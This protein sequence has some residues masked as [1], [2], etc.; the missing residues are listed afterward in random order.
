MKNIHITE[1][2]S[3]T[4]APVK[5]DRFASGVGFK[6]LTKHYDYLINNFFNVDE[7]IDRFIGQIDVRPGMKLL[8]V[9]C[10]TGN[11]LISL[12]S[13]IPGV[14]LFGIDID[15]EMIS[16]S[17]NKMDLA[18]LN[19]SVKLIQSSADVLPFEPESLDR[20]VSSLALHHLPA[21][22]R[23]KHLKRSFEILKPG[24][25]LH[26]MDWGKPVSLL[27]HVGATF[28]ILTDGYS[29]FS[30][31]LRGKIPERIAEAG[32]VEIQEYNTR[33]ETFGTLHFYS[34]LKPV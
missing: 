6:F 16:I 9:G 34:A 26:V 4:M 23:R 25:S 31:S 11:L 33:N 19:G 22:T 5:Q 30:D 29:C 12:H 20:V 1:E 13:R 7:I 21:E 28:E 14:Q 8:D 32:F 18:G 24:G 15:P 10:G 27:Q 3:S 17:R 2:G